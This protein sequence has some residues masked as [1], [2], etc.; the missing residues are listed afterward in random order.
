MDMDNNSQRTV[1]VVK[2]GGSLFELRNLGQRLHRWLT[3]RPCHEVLLVP[4]GGSIADVVRHYDALHG[5]GEERAH[6][7]ALSA[8]TVNARF[9]AS[10]LPRAVVVPHPQ[11][12]A[13]LWLHGK[14][15][16]L[17]G[18]AFALADEGQSGCLPHCWKVTSDSV[19]ARAA[20]VARAGELILLKSASCPAGI[21]W[22]EAG[23]RGLVDTYFTDAVGSLSPVHFLNFRLD[24]KAH[25]NLSL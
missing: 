24:W 13:A 1:S 16:I 10:L 23:K 14:I 17:D 5:L 25:D 15:P 19:A 11:A 9:L 2:V 6:W 4:G 22:A 7:L 3:E 12:C 8:L 21:D 20:H 18:Y